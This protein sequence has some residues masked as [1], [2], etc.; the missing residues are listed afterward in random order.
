M[1]PIFLNKDCLYRKSDDQTQ[2]S[3]LRPCTKDA[4]RHIKQARSIIANSRLV[5]EKGARAF[6]FDYGLYARTEQYLAI[7]ATTVL[8]LGRGL[9]SFPFQLNLSLLCRSPLD[10]SS[11]CP[12]YNPN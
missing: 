2:R 7:E 8:A 3:E 5:T 1:H 6:A 10:L 9:H 12:P 11:L 4:I